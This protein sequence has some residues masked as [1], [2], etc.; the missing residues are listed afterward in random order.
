MSKAVHG[1]QNAQSPRAEA[2][3]VSSVGALATLLMLREQLAGWEPGLIE[4]ARAAGTSWA[5]FV[6]N[7][8]ELR[9]CG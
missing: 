5:D 7:R 2:E 1:A 9:R 4:T 8:R 6:R 3:Q